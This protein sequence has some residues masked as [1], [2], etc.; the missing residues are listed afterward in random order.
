MR[1]VRECVCVS[2]RPWRGG[3]GCLDLHFSC[4][5]CILFPSSK[6][7]LMR[8]AGHSQ[9]RAQTVRRHRNTVL[10]A[11]ALADTHMTLQRSTP[12]SPQASLCLF[13]TSGESTVKSAVLRLIWPWAD[14]SLQSLF[15]I[16]AA[17]SNKDLLY[18]TTNLALHV[19]PLLPKFLALSVYMP[20]PPLYSCSAA[21][22]IRCLMH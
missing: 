5:V 11:T 6:K 15:S 12:T 19:R 10:G 13:I 8:Q 22:Q 1:Y 7:L 21:V 14:G 17:S 16:S 4:L 9:K 2:V 18:V 20:P 3:G